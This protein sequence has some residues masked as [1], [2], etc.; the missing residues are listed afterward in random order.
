MT[1]LKA[2]NTNREVYK[3]TQCSVSNSDDEH[4]E[5]LEQKYHPKPLKD[6]PNYLRVDMV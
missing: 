1:K 6:Q 3:L 5:R 2:E 4:L